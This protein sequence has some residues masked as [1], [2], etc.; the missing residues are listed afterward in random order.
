MKSEKK[1]KEDET[2]EDTSIHAIILVSIIGLGTIL[3]IL[4]LIGL[5]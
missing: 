2:K 5:F 3:V 1:Q 4:K